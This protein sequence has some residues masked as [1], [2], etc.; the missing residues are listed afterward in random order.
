MQV[1]EAEDASTAHAGTPFQDVDASA[2]LIAV[3]CQVRITEEAE[4][5]E[6]RHCFRGCGDVGTQPTVRVPQH[7]T[8]W[9]IAV[10]RRRFTETLDLCG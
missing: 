5:S 6:S 10:R 8:R 2:A 1:R 4:D 7:H 9:N 3:G